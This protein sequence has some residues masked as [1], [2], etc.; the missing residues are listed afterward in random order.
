[1]AED[2]LP[3]ALLVREAIKSEDLPSEVFIAADGERVIDMIAK[4]EAD[5]EAPCPD[6]LLLDLNLPRI[7]GF[8]VLRRVRASARFKDLPVLIVTS[9]DSPAD[10]DAA[11]KLGA[12]YFRK[13][14]SYEE[15]LRVGAFLRQFLEEHG[16]L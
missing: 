9:S 12:R 6:L 7:D 11:A 3:D 4:A 2:N 10:R 16:L 5:A 1:L 8:D 13:P 14:V 15:Y